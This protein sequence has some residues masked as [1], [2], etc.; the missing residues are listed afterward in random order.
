MTRNRKQPV[1]FGLPILVATAMTLACSARCLA[2]EIDGFTE[3]YK[4]VNVAA[5]ETGTIKSIEVREGESVEE[6]QIVARLDDEV[7]QALLNI[8][9]ESMHA[10]G[11]LNSAEAEVK[12]RRRRL[13][14]LEAL[15]EQGHARQE[16]VERARA[17][18]EIAEAQLLSAHEQQQVR[19]LEYDKVQVQLERRVIRTPIDGVVNLLHKDVGEFVAPNDPD[20]LELVCLDP[21]MATF[22]VPSYL[23][24]R[25]SLDQTVSV[26]LDD[27][28]QWVEGQVAIIA[29]VT[30]AESSTVRIKVRIS[31]ADRKYRSG[32]HCTLQFESTRSNSR[33]SPR[34]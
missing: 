3:P 23:A 34:R 18:L 11:Q 28:E 29:P 30:D 17:D 6:G 31:N 5:V 33:R 12:M 8:A 10:Q 21:L 26:Y 14:K 15:R 7:H 16:E 20:V 24:T 32:E 19:R 1:N 22:N 27:V 9:A 2:N 4:T 25:L 13:E